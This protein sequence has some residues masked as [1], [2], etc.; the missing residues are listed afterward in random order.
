M[1]FEAFYERDYR[2]FW[3]TQ[4]ISNIGSWMQGI[5]QGWLVYHLTD[6]PFLLGFVGFANSIPQFFLMLPGGVVADRFDRRRV[7]GASQWVQTLAALWLAISIYTHHIAVWQIIA[8]AIVT[9]VAMSF[10]GPAY[11]AMV[12]DLLD[13]RSRLPNAIAM[14]SLQFNLS[15]AIGP[16]IA[17]V[18]LSLYGPFWCFFFNA[19]SFLPLI[20]VLRIVRPRQLRHPS[21]EAAMLSHIAEAFRYVRRDRL[22]VILLGIVA[23]ASLFGYPYLNLMP[24]IARALFQNDAKGLGLLMGGIGA[25][26]LAGSL[27]LSVRM[28][29]QHRMIKTILFT[30]ATFGLGLAGIGFTR[31]QPAVF[32]LL[33][34]CGASMVV[35]VALCN[36]TIQQRI[37]DALRG[38]V[39]SMY[40]FAFSGFLPFGNLF[41]GILAEH[42][43]F[44]PTMAMLGGGLLLTA[45]VAAPIALRD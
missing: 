23:A 6:S 4:F 2:L 32:A 39:L 30:L 43:G 12:V 14:N 20:W 34:M 35:C 36:T 16:L 15:R 24:M 7:V 25:G 10:S 44:Q 37:P 33:V 13:D 38:R 31:Q 42:R 18:T 17:G 28:P 27:V 40:T 29:L 41:G 26:A 22:V 11:Q 45:A 19:I 8:A 9:G 3:T 21:S 1:A 5:A